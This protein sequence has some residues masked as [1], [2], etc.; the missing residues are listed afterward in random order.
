MTENKVLEFWFAELTEADW[1]KKNIEL[2]HKIAER[3]LS[4][5]SC[6]IRGEL[7]DWRKTIEGRLAEIIVLDQFSRNIFR[8]KPESFQWDSLAL[9]LAQEASGLKVAKELS[10][11]K[12]GFLYMPY[13]HSESL[14]V[15]EQSVKLFSEPGL[16]K[17]LD[18]EL[19]H[20]KIIEKFGRYPH[21]N[22]I[23][24]RE[25][26]AEEVVFLKTPGS[27]F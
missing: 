10:P 25:S 2:D 20:K 11:V 16:E 3:F 8:N 15:H 21:R 18:F 4:I 22:E 1:F 6:A 17:R 9:V 5:H 19:K 23:L 7:F 14:K 26:T 27:S 24:G 13:M 12:K